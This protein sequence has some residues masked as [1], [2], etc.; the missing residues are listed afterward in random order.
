MSVRL[1]VHPIRKAT[2]YDREQT[3]T[4]EGKEKKEKKKRA[5][6]FARGSFSMLSLAITCY[7]G[8][9]LREAG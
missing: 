8:Y 3:Q 9:Y 6:R 2:K 7:P 5:T 1:Y 4:Q